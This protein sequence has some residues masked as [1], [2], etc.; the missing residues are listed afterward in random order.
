VANGVL[1]L[2]R[3]LEPISNP[4]L[5]SDLE[6][7]AAMAQAAIRGALANVS[8]NLKSIRDEAFSHEMRQRVTAVEKNSA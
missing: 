7:G 3:Q 6:T 4:N 1:Q 2:L 8:I 5:R